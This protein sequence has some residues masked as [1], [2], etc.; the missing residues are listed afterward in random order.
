MC[1]LRDGSQW[2][3]GDYELYGGGSGVGFS[4]GKMQGFEVIVPGKANMEHTIIPSTEAKS[5]KDG[6]TRSIAP[7]RYG[8]T[9][10]QN[11][12]KHSTDEKLIPVEKPNVSEIKDPALR[13]GYF[14]KISNLIDCMLH[15]TQLET[16]QSSEISLVR[17]LMATLQDTNE[18]SNGAMK[19]NHGVPSDTDNEMGLKWVHLGAEV[20]CKM[21]VFRVEMDGFGC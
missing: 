11:D 12:G 7:T 9:Q 6:G 2:P 14:K 16:S 15:L 17:P 5:R 3:F 21:Y 8:T 19:C 4:S 13:Q 18:D 1:N 20:T 10:V